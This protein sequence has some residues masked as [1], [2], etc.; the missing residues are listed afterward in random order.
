DQVRQV[1]RR[2]VAREIR[3]RVQVS[4][5]AS[6]LGVAECVAGDIHYNKT[7]LRRLQ[8]VTLEDIER[9]AE[10]YLKPEESLTLTLSPKS[11]QKTSTVSSSKGTYSVQIES[12]QFANGLR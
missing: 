11:L 10:T 12:G 2:A 9:V 4:G 3:S 5:Q 8:E 7:M 6:K 1:V